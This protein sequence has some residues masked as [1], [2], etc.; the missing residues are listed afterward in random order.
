MS[1]GSAVGAGVEEVQEELA[2]QGLL[3]PWAR[4]TPVR[5]EYGGVHIDPAAPAGDESGFGYVDS[6]GLNFTNTQIG[7]IGTAFISNQRARGTIDAPEDLQDGDGVGWYMFSAMINNGTFFQA[8]SG[9]NASVNINDDGDISSVL[10]FGVKRASDQNPTTAGAFLDNH[11]FQLT[12]YPSTR[13]DG[14]SPT[15]KYL[16]VD[17]QGILRFGVISVYVVDTPDDD[18]NQTDAFEQIAQVDAPGN[19]PAGWYELIISGEYSIDAVS[20]DYEGEVR[21]GTTVLGR[22]VRTEGKDA[23]G[24]GIATDGDNSGTDQRKP[25]Y[26]RRLLQLPENSTASFNYRHR[27]SN[28]GVEASTFDIVFSLE[29]KRP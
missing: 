2:N 13:D 5:I 15:G 4:T 21:Q 3:T 9:I 17:A 8:V 1:V 16:Y 26:I 11:D 28:D 19:G 24:G 12:A 18:I 10:N 20:A 29:F 27:S 14:I 25:L 23:G 7:T 6:T 22:T